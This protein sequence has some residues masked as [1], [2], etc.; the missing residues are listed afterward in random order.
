MEMILGIVSHFEFE[1]ILATKCFTKIKSTKRFVR[2]DL[3]AYKM[4]EQSV[5][6]CEFGDN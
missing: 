2:I 3:P 6:Q 1:K 5:T 4:T